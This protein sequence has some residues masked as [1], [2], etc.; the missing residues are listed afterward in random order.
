M[1][2]YYVIGKKALISVVICVEL[3]SLRRFAGFLDKEH[4]YGYI[5]II[6]FASQVVELA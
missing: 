3:W 5:V 6:V 2:G 4:I 1:E